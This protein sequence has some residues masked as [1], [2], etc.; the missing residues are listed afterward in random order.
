MYPYYESLYHKLQHTLMVRPI[1]NIN[2]RVFN[3]NW[4]TSSGWLESLKCMQSS[5]F[6]LQ[7]QG[8]YLE[9]T[10]VCELIK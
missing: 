6:Q 3:K 10:F 2:G 4:V 7:T 5:I 8:W 1:Q 9:I